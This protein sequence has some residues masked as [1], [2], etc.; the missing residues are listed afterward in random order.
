MGSNLVRP[1]PMGSYLVRPFPMGSNL[2]RPFPMGSNLV[3]PFPFWDR[4]IE[5]SEN[6]KIQI[7]DLRQIIT[8][9]NKTIQSNDMSISSL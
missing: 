1:F 5:E 6:L 9:Q 4:S 3:R 2:V 7:N 8:N